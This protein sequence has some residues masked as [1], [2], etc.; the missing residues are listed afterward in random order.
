MISFVYY[1]HSRRS[2]NLR[3]SLR[4]LFKRERCIREVILVCNDRTDE[5]FDNCRLY[6]MEMSDYR[7]PAMCNFGVE[8]ASGDIVA[9]LDSDRILPAGYFGE[10]SSVA[11]RGAFYSCERMLNLTRPHTDEEIDSGNLDHHVEM[12]SRDCEIRRKNLFSGNTTFMKE[13]YLLA[14]GMDER[15]VGY[16]F[17]DNDMTYNIARV[18]MEAVWMGGDE[19]H[20]H[21][22]KETMEAGEIVGFDKY[23]NTSQR[24]LNR[25]LRKWR[26]KGHPD[27]NN[28]MVL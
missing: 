27:H 26:I 25:F 20:L 5:R 1:F 18:G 16:G 17:A 9:I 28:K 14:G 15:F 22:E 2:E 6:N 7:K 12:K 24:N 21:H 10:V 11:R 23:R 19:I 13:D 4:M 8:K 3:Q